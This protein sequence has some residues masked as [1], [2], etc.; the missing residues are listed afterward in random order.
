LPYHDEYRGDGVFFQ[1]NT[2]I[3]DF[4]SLLDYTRRFSHL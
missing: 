1:K 4:F 3:L 2:E